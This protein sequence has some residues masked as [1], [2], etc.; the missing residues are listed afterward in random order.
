MTHSEFVPFSAVL[1]GIK[2][3]KA[4]M[5]DAERNAQARPAHA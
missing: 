2:E 1:T 5:A 4:V 3:I